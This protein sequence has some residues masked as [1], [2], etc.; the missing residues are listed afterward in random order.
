MHC[1]ALL[2][3]ALISTQA[4]A[5]KWQLESADWQLLYPAAIDQAPYSLEGRSTSHVFKEAL[6]LKTEAKVEVHELVAK[7]QAFQT[8]ATDPSFSK[9][10]LAAYRL[11]VGPSSH[12]LEIQVNGKAL[13]LIQPGWSHYSISLSGIAK[14]SNNEISV[15]L[16]GVQPGDAVWT[17]WP[18]LVVEECRIVSVDLENGK[19]PSLRITLSNPHGLMPK[20]TALRFESTLT[21]AGEAGEVG[22]KRGSEVVLNYALDSIPKWHASTGHFASGSYN[23][24]IDLVGGTALLSGTIAQS[25]LAFGDDNVLRTHGQKE[26]LNAAVLQPHI[27]MDTTRF[28]SW[29]RALAVLRHAGGNT[30]VWPNGQAPEA[31]LKACLHLGVYVFDKGTRSPL[32]QK[33]ACRVGS[34]GPNGHLNVGTSDQTIHAGKGGKGAWLFTG[35]ADLEGNGLGGWYEESLEAESDERCCGVM[36]PCWVWQ[37]GKLIDA[38]GALKPLMREVRSA[39]QPITVECVEGELLF[40]KRGFN[41]STAG[42]QV[43]CRQM[44]NGNPTVEMPSQTIQWEGDFAALDVSGVWFN[45]DQTENN[46]CV[47]DVRIIDL[48]RQQLVP[49]PYELLH[50]QV[51]L[52]IPEP[53]EI[54]PVESLWEYQ[55]D[56][57]HLEAG[58]YRY[59]ISAIDGL[60]SQIMKSG[61]PLLVAPT[62]LQFWSPKADAHLPGVDAEYWSRAA[63][64]MLV[65]FAEENGAEL[66]FH[67]EYAEGKGLLEV[68]YQVDSEGH[69]WIDLEGGPT[70]METCL[71]RFGMRWFFDADKNVAN[72]YGLG[73]GSSYSDRH[74]GAYWGQHT[75]EVS[76]MAI[77]YVGLDENGYHHQAYQLGIGTGQS[78]CNFSAIDEP[79]GF[80]VLPFA[81]EQLRDPT[82]DF[83]EPSPFTVVSIDGFMAG[84]SGCG[85]FPLSHEMY[86]LSFVLNPGN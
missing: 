46:H 81:R 16:V 34:V 76:R 36:L 77:P 60:P 27:G 23:F 86:H 44:C 70:G 24:E 75:A 78:A 4:L 45:D 8:T 17:E 50:E 41:R 57:Y 38:Q 11:V 74:Q 84:L 29:D 47:L 1:C 64:R 31:L 53:L 62:Q 18:A 80:S 48:H 5:Q 3:T 72:W 7:G 37:P 69:L 79:F 49:V 2:V 55:N 19:N 15:R 10:R 83:S 63:N 6:R 32:A 35:N 42:L 12:A 21:A 51:G 9:A 82:F 20:R 73:R 28:A 68:R 66:V 54:A 33:Y 14:G 61:T 56:A 58:K 67:L 25:E 39:W 65:L 22:M 85:P 13:P 40:Y 30:V 43:I 71:P 59:S 52:S 26:R